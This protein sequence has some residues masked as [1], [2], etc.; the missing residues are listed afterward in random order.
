MLAG[1]YVVTRVDRYV[2]VLYCSGVEMGVVTV[3]VELV[4]RNKT[5]FH[6]YAVSHNY[7]LYLCT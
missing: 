5:V 6:Y 4:Y 3:D 1:R 7:I 2:G